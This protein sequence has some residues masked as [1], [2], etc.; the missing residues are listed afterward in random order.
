MGKN[1]IFVSL[2]LCVLSMVWAQARAQLGQPAPA[3]A[4]D[5]L[6]IKFSASTS[7]SSRDHALSTAGLRVIDTFSLVPGLVFTKPVVGQKSANSVSALAA[8]PSIEYI[9]PDYIVSVAQA[10]NDPVYP[11]LYALNNTGQTGGTANADI[12]A[13]EAW[14]ITTGKNVIVAVID[15]GVDYNHDDLRANMWINPGEIPDNGIDDDNNGYVDDVHGYDFT[16]NNGSPM[17]DF[18][19]GTHVAGIIGAT[20]NNGLGGVGVNWS[21]RIMALKFM[22]AKG[23]GTTG[24]AIRAV[25]YAVAMGARISNAS[26][27]GGGY[28][29][30]MYDTLAAANAAGHVFITASGN[31]STDTESVPHYPSGYDLP[32]VISVAATTSNDVFALFSNYG[33]NAIDLAAP[34]ERIESTFKGNTYQTLTGTSMASPYVAGAASLLLSLVPD[35]SVSK[36]RSALLDT[37]DPLPTLQGK[38]A[39]GGRLNL[40]KAMQSLTVNMVLAPQTARISINKTLQFNVTGGVGPYRW[41]LS[42]PAVGSIGAADGLLVTTGSG[43]TRVTVKDVLGASVT[44]GDIFVDQ[45]A[46]TPQTAVLQVGGSLK[47]TVTGGVAPYRFASS[48]PN[49]ASV[50]PN[51]DLAALRAGS[52]LVSATDQ[53]GV[54]TRTGIIRINANVVTVPALLV[55]PQTAT[56][57]PGATQQFIASGGVPPY[58]WTSQNSS[59]ASIT[60]DGGL[61]TALTFGDTVVTVQDSL[62][63]VLSTGTVTVAGLRISVPANFSTIYVGDSLQLSASGG[64]PPYEW[65]VSDS[66]VVSMDAVTGKLFAIMPGVVRVT[67]MDKANNTARSGIITVVAT[68]ILKVAAATTLLVPGQ[69][70]Q[71]TVSGG[72]QPYR[73]SVTNSAVVAVSEAAAMLTGLSPGMAAVNVTDAAGASVTTGSIEVRQVTV[74]PS[75]GS[76]S[77]GQVIGLTASGGRGPYRW[78]VSDPAA[79][80]IDA[81]G[82]LVASRAGG[83]TVTATDA[84]N[85]AGVSLTYTFNAV[86]GVANVVQIKPNT[87]TLSAKGSSMAF[88]AVGG[89]GPYTYSLSNTNVGTID[90]LTGVLTP[91]KLSVGDTTVI[92]K[93]AAGNVAESGLIGVR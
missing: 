42:N 53:N 31:E 46:I 27:G 52:V 89:A 60:G 92:A 28:S 77:V 18:G 91:K 8:N 73:W 78:T 29:Q 30:A 38:V 59:I 90:P 72:V 70:V 88:I 17:D 32:N 25:N 54:E 7:R 57:S 82:N 93:D 51:G 62:G 5:G 81:A 68:N 41:S 23:F 69:S 74:A 15:T 43:V 36:I 22:D 75:G 35:L 20:A 33:S 40:L 21:A 65:R 16:I 87:A 3:V 19:H 48:D 55:N 4:S 85:V 64:V 39:T 24:N 67:V 10:P 13:P 44:S 9:E 6:I 45:L 79:A 76:Y 49:V 37:V 61:L 12:N 71:L 47:L 14:D 86:G 26:W 66:S 83:L 11:R 2:L 58:R 80:T 34:G 50:T 63:T 56:L 1:G 84:D